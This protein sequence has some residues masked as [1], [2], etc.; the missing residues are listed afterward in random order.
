MYLITWYGTYE[1]WNRSLPYGIPLGY[2]LEAALHLAALSSVPMVVV[3]IYNS[4]KYKTGKMRPFS[5]AARPFFPFLTYLILLMY[6]TFKSPNNI[7]ETDPRAVYL[8]AGTIF[9]NISVSVLKQI[10]ILVKLSLICYVFFSV[11]F[12]CSPNVKHTL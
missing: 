1:F 9:S 7:I 6:W 10:I 8:L 3:N 12:N 11:S 2:A 5:E 4:Y